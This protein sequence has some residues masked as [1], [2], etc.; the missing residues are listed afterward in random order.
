M[1]RAGLKWPALTTYPDGL[2]PELRRLVTTTHLFSFNAVDGRGCGDTTPV[3]SV[4]ARPF[5]PIC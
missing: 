5:W 4:I 1:A 2:F 3:S